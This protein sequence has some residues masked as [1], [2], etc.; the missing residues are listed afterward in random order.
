MLL[1]AIDYDGTYSLDPEI[2]NIIIQILKKAGHE[3]ICVTGRS[4]DK[5]SDNVVRASIG[6]LVPVIFAGKKYKYDAAKDAGFYVDIWIDDNPS[7]I[8]I[9]TLK[10]GWIID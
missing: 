6:K 9:P 10:G 4:G 5:E 2:F 3:V 1:F 8:S 7:S